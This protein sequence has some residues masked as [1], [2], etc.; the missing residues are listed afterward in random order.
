[1]HRFIVLGILMIFVSHGSSAQE[2]R[3]T[4][5][6]IE[7]LQSDSA[8]D[9][10]GA[11][12]YV[13]GAGIDDADLYAAIAKVIEVRSADLSDES[14]DVELKEISTHLK[15]LG[16]S[17]NAMYMPLLETLSTSSVKYVAKHADK[18][19]KLLQRTSANGAPY[20]ESRRVTEIFE[21]QRANC[22]LVVQNTCS[23]M[24]SVEKCI[25]W[26]K[27][28]ASEKGANAIMLLRESRVT[29]KRHVVANYF[30]CSTRDLASPELISV[31]LNGSVNVDNVDVETPVIPSYI[32]ELKE[33][34]T[35]RDNGVITEAEFQSEKAE[36]LD[37]N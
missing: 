17:G 3:S 15:A 2:T 5:S 11:S 12:R 27:Q 36:I 32:T 33:L 34:A 16:G 1:M 28:R 25:N 10:I 13:Y 29:F 22:D 31:N 4:A 9:R 18:A 23:T 14:S 20:L 21:G 26:H 37:S 19:I 8:Q 7:Q 24:R 30:R 6:L 35:L